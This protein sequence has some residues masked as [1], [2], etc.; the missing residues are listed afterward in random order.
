ME[1]TTKQL[2][3]AIRD[4]VADLEWAGIKIIQID[5]PAF[6]EAAPLRLWGREA[7]FKW[8]V[9]GFHIATSVVNDDTQIHTHMCYSDFN[10]IIDPI[11]ALDADVLLIE[12]SRSNMNLLKAFRDKKYLN[13]IGVGVFDVHSPRIPTQ[14]E[15]EVLILRAMLYFDPEQIWINPD[16]GLKTRNWNEVGSSLTNMVR[17]ATSLR[18]EIKFGPKKAADESAAIFTT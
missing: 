14:D 4:E 17:A 10:S 16:C 8:A 11:V 1:L 3:L 7:Y 13:G 6:R 15:I 5:E 2:A 9:E 12:A 18:N